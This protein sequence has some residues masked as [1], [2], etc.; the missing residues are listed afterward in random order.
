LWRL[1]AKDGTKSGRRARRAA[2]GKYF[3][4]MMTFVLLILGLTLFRVLPRERM[5]G[6][7]VEV[8]ERSNGTLKVFFQGEIWAAVSSENLSVG[9]KVE[10]LGI[11][12]EERMK[13]R[14][15]RAKAL[16]HDVIVARLS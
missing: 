7:K 6:S 4:N 8:I 13:V 10:I 15:G 11:H 9:E 14:V 5:I 1:V 16:C 12:K 3:E 2:P